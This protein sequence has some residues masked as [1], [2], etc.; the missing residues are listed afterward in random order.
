MQRKKLAWLYAAGFLG[1]F[2]I[3]HTPGFTDANGLLFGLFKI[4]PI[5]DVV[6]LLSGIA[7]VFVAWY[8]TRYIILYFKAVGILY[9]LDAIIGLTQGRGFLDLSIFF[10]G[11]GAPDFSLTNLAVNF[12]HIVIAGIALVIGFRKSSAPQTPGI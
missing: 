4:D 6:H 1:V 12:P 3:T 10:Q 11:M 8:A 7:G 5:D 9:G 2:L